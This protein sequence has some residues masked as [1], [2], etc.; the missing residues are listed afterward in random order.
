MSA[1]QNDIDQQDQRD[2][3]HWR[4]GEPSEE[5]DR[6]FGRDEAIF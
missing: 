2:H 6:I 1:I 4:D 5:S 3:G